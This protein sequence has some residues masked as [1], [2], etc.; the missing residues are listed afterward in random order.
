MLRRVASIL[1]GHAWTVLADARH[2]VRP[3]SV[4]AWEPWSLVVADEVAG[5]VRLGGRL[6]LSSARKTAVLVVHG[7]GG[8]SQSGYSRALARA[9]AA[10]GWSSLRIDLRG[11]D[12]LGEDVYHAGLAPDLHAA[13]ESLAQRGHETVHVVGVSL[14]GHA[15]LRLAL[16]PPAGLGAV[17]AVSSPLDLAAS[18]RAIDRR[19]A[20]AYRH[21][22]LRSLKDAYASVVRTH[23]D[24]A[25][26]PSPIAEVERARTIW[27][28]DRLVVVPRY[29]FA[30]VADYHRSMSV[31]PH[32]HAVQVPTLYVGSPFDPMVPGETVLPSLQAAR[33]AVRVVMLE[34]GGHVGLPAP[35]LDE[36]APPTLPDQLMAWL[37][38]PR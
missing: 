1:G 8:S 10:R 9:A 25:R 24:G 18:C 3:V 27:D 23:G 38:A 30:D 15:T 5:D 33:D 6:S 16:Q 21:H 22:V 12:G 4:P 31:G 36:D 13:V 26:A 14:G 2:R 20:F 19:R 32:L 11:A 28:W 37:D 29:G 17:I 34:S 7:L 35:R